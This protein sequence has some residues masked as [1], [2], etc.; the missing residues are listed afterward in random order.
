MRKCVSQT[1]HYGTGGQLVS[2][3][4][5]G[6]RFLR[7]ITIVLALL[8]AAAT[9]YVSSQ[10]STSNPDVPASAS[11]WLGVGAIAGAVFTM[12]G[13]YLS[14]EDPVGQ[15][16]L[17]TGLLIGAVFAFA[18]PLFC[19]PRS[20]HGLAVAYLLF[21]SVMGAYG[22]LRAYL[23]NRERSTTSFDPADQSD[24]SLKAQVGVV[25]QSM[26]QVVNVQTADSAK[27]SHLV[28]AFASG[29]TAAALVFAFLG[30][31]RRR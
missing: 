8:I 6:K 17:G 28:V 12:L 22:C 7:S 23:S 18:I 5:T 14:A 29:A 26:T 11:T 10:V 3:A 24:S 1:I 4:F 21:L 30:F 15:S 27:G 16:P 25:P 2:T 31:S 19:W 20:Y 13:A 9:F